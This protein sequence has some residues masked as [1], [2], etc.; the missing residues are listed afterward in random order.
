METRLHIILKAFRHTAHS[1]IDPNFRIL[2]PILTA[3]DSYT[4]WCTD[5]TSADSFCVA[6]ESVFALP[7]SSFFLL[8]V[9]T[10]ARRSCEIIDS[11]V[12]MSMDI[13]SVDALST[14]LSD[15][16]QES[17]FFIDVIARVYLSTLRPALENSLQD[18]AIDPSVDTM[19]TAD[20]CSQ[21]ANMEAITPST[22]TKTFMT[23]RRRVYMGT[24]RLKKDKLGSI[25]NAM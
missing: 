2:S 11:L 18:V 7:L 22:I 16:H 3:K 23:R 14:S 13:F 19:V 4:R 25:R 10:Q 5:A 21:R 24:R 6:S 17:I 1:V 20:T 9:D 15:F 8:A 12:S